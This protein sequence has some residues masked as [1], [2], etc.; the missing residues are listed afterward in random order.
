MTET[1]LNHLVFLEGSVIN[2]RHFNLIYIYMA[3]YKK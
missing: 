1:L 3:S 2:H